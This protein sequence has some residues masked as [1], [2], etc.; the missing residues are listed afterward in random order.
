[1][2]KKKEAIMLLKKYDALCH[3]RE[4]LRKLVGM[5]GG[6]VHIGALYE[7][8]QVVGIIKKGLAALTPEQRLIL[9]RF[10]I[11]REKGHPQHLCQALGVEHSSVYRRKEKALAKFIEAIYGL[12]DN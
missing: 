12:M 5:E 4:N 8:E 7:T 1:M 11:Y 2:D 10:Y 9:S 6:E 3:A